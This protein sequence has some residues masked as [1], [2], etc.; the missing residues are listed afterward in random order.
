MEDYLLPLHTP[1]VYYDA[2]F[3]SESEANDAYQYLV[4]NTPWEKTPKINRWVTLMELSPRSNTDNNS[5]TSEGGDVKEVNQEQEVAVGYRYRDAPGASIVGPFPPVV[6]K[7]KLLAEEWY[8][9]KRQKQQTCDT[10]KHVEFNVCLLNYYQDGT[11]RIG[12]H[13]DREELGRTTPIASISLGA[14]RQFLIRSKTDGMRDRAS[15]SMSHGSMVVME[16]I[17]QLNYLHSV[18]KEMEVL[19]GRI[20]LT[21]RCKKEGE[22]GGTTLGEI[23]HEKRDHWIDQI[24]TEEGVLDSTAGPWKEMDE[25]E[26]D[27]VC[28]GNPG[29]RMITMLGDSGRHA[30]F[31]DSARFYNSVC[32]S[33]DDIAKSVEFVVRTNIGA[34]CYCAAEI[35]EVLVMER[36]CCLA[37]PFGIAG[38]VAVCRRVIGEGEDD[39][40]E[41]EP[42]RLEAI[43]L[44]LRT[45]HHVLR[46]HDHFDL[47]QV[48]SASAVTE[49]ET[50]GTSNDTSDDGEQVNPKIS[51]I[52]GEMLYEYYKARLVSMN[53]RILSLLDLDKHGGT[54][55]VSCERIGSGHGFQAPE[56]ERCSVFL[57]FF[58]LAMRTHPRSHSS[59][60][61]V[62]T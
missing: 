45:A 3:L 54:F 18:P 60:F 22:E 20:N 6:N 10:S 24:S 25:G 53:A 47:G 59:F 7:L 32:Q 5:T 41:Y 9:S 56:L 52:T 17:C 48:L 40:K 16:N 44:Q 62:G 33:E 30:V 50:D 61:F 42:T 29:N 21:F 1:C 36:Y 31:G 4:A 26:E 43:L 57:C 35:E 14:P 8:N 39:A 15:I 27:G 28:G 11:Q 13:S 51:S 55:R 2:N 46:Y 38:Y 12:W 19:E 58:T 49:L 34:E 23:E 37:R